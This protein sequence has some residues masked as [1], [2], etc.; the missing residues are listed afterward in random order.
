M[1]SSP[2]RTLET[3]DDNALWLESMLCA[4]RWQTGTDANGDSQSSWFC[5]DCGLEIT[6]PDEGC[7]HCGYGRLPE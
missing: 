2:T 6:D 4:D 7:E 1:A 3:I 5:R